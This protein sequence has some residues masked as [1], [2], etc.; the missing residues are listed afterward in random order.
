MGKNEAASF[1]K[2]NKAFQE[3]MC[4]IMLDE[5]PF[6]DQ[7]MEVLN[8][9]F[10]ELKF[11]QVFVGKIF[12]YKTKY[13]THPSRDIMETVLRTDLSDL[14]EILQKQTREYYAR[15]ITS[16]FDTEKAYIKNEALDFCRRQKLHEA[17]LQ[18]VKQIQNSKFDEVS[19]I[20]NDALKLG[21]ENDLGYD[22]IKDFEQR[23]V[24]NVRFPIATGW[25]MVDE[26]T[27]GGNGR[28]EYAV[29]IA[30]SGFGKS[31]VLVN[32]AANAIREGKNVVFY[33]L[34]LSKEVIALRTDAC[35]SQIAKDDLKEHKDE[36]YKEIIK[37]PG[38]FIVKHYP[39]NTVSTRTIRLHLDKLIQSG[40]KPDMVIIDYAELLKPLNNR[41][42]VRQDIGDI[43]NEFETICQEYNV[44][45]W[46]AS[47]TNRKGLSA[48]I[49]SME[50]ISEAFNK[51]FGA[52]LII[53]LSRSVQDKNSNT[54]KFFVAK[55]RNGPDGI[56][57]DI[58]MDTALSTIKVLGQRKGET[59]ESN[60][61]KILQ[62]AWGKYK[63]Q[64]KLM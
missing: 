27:D 23:Y 4:L 22:Y 31:Q 40:F 36:V 13:K 8:L 42:E 28:G 41:K 59:G 1:S 55:N 35:I 12:E 20:I 33:T 64:N 15:V 37:I 62:N 34:E 25:P 10:L 44:A 49:V 9:E 52:Y 3:K 24:D 46:T 30:P 7:M 58:F 39:K 38:R 16:D 6:A 2:Y 32:L 21:S 11:L 5:R 54:G 61:N 50:E 14:P 48:E 60:P 57:Y 18:A 47:Q 17:M 29:I 19:K 63:E 51:C 56:I 43:Y 53:T 45:G 26:I